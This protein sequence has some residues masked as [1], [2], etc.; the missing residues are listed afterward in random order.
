M[1]QDA[2]GSPAS[3]TRKLV[4]VLERTEQGTRLEYL[5][6]LPESL[7]LAVSEEDLTEI[8]GPLL[9]NAVRF[10]RRRVQVA[11]EIRDGRLL[12]CVEDDGPGIKASEAA[13]ALKRGTRLD[14]TGGGHGLGLS[15]ARELVEA[16]G[17]QIA[18][19]ESRL[20]GLR[21]E[22]AWEAATEIPAPAAQSA[23]PA[24]DLAQ[25]RLAQSE[26]K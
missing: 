19:S 1:R 26:I 25:Q 23:R 10:A 22:L 4:S 2:K 15:I 13:Q 5:V 17:G 6:Y 9:E 11:S 8:L 14:E 24:R 3:V 20:G 18:L 7:R 21:V 16:T 12:L